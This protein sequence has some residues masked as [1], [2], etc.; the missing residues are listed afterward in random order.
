MKFKY[1][2]GDVVRVT[3]ELNS[4]QTIVSYGVVTGLPISAAFGDP[5]WE[6]GRRYRV[7][8]STYFDDYIELGA[9]ESELTGADE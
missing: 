9:L 3:T 7:R 6:A 5:T 2:L 4:A 1:K 8:I